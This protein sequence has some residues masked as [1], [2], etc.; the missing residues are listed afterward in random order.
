MAVFGGE[1][2]SA[3]RPP[4]DLRLDLGTAHRRRLLNWP[5]LS[6]NSQVNKTTT[7]SNRSCETQ[8]QTCRPYTFQIKLAMDRPVGP[9]TPP[10]TARAPER[11]PIVGQHSTLVPLTAEHAPSL[12]SHVAGPEREAAWTYMSIT[13]PPDLTTFEP[14]VAQWA[15]SSDPFYYAVVGGKDGKEALGMMSYLSIVPEHRRI[16]IGWVM[17]GDKLKRTRIATEAF[18]G[19]MKHAFDDLG[20]LRVEWKCHSLNKASWSAAERL[21]FTYEGTFR[22]DLHFIFST[23]TCIELLTLT[24]AAHYRQRQKERQRLLQRHQGGVASREEGSGDMA[25]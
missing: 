6:T 17:L 1:P 5:G 12:F 18:Y 20:Y 7:D 3:A 15:A 14:Y 22:Y 2:A 4:F 9:D 24:Q 10:G 11:T 21:G 13:S 23:S 25:P 19:M 8:L 16:E